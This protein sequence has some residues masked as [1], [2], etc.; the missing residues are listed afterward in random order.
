LTSPK[1]RAAALARS[2]RSLLSTTTAE[3]DSTDRTEAMPGGSRV[4]W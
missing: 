4:G 2:T 1:A 3:E